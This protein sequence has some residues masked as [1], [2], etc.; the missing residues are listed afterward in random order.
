MG[1]TVYGIVDLLRGRRGF[2]VFRILRVF[3]RVQG[4]RSQIGFRV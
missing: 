2:R 1:I 4:S 3:K